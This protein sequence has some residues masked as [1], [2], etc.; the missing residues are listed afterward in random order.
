MKARLI[1]EAKNESERD[2]LVFVSH[3]FGW[4]SE[5]PKDYGY[6][7]MDIV[8][9]LTYLYDHTHAPD[10]K[11]FKC[12]VEF[13]KDRKYQTPDEKDPSAGFEK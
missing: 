9:M 10:G 13:P 3:C 6:S 8:R 2:R 1:L 5:K 4:C 12:R 11:G 7:M